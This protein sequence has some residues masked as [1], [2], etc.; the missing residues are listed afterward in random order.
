MENS[1]R[2][3]WHCRLQSKHLGPAGIFADAR[4]FGNGT[5]RARVGEPE[6]EL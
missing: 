6:S 5:Q 4:A 3:E 1:F 2:N